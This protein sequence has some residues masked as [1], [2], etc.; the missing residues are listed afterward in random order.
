MSLECFFPRTFRR[1]EVRRV[2]IPRPSYLEG[3][4]GLAAWAVVFSHSAL[5]FFPFLHLESFKQLAVLLASIPF[6]IWVDQNA[7]S[8]GNRWS[9]W[10]VSWRKVRAFIQGVFEVLP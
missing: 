6:Q 9:Q 1:A 3:M 7:V 8:L 5:A 4:R 10:L 2:E